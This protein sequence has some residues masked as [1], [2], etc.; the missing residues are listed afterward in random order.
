MID[1]FLN[2][3]SVTEIMTVVT[4]AMKSTA[5]PVSINIIIDHQCKVH[6]KSSLP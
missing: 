2:H 6:S 3:G 5:P 1:V 4:T